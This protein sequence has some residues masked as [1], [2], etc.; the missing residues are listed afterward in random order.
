MFQFTHFFKGT[1]NMHSVRLKKQKAL[2]L[3]LKCIIINSTGAKNG[4]YTLQAISRE[5]YPKQNT[6]R[7]RI[8]IDNLENSNNKSYKN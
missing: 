3:L 7:S 8:K 5:T 1:V 6:D 2:R 4:V